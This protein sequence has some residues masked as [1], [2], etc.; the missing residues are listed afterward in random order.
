MSIKFRLISFKRYETFKKS[1]KRSKSI[2]NTI[3]NFENLSKKKDFKYIF[4][5]SREYELMK[6][7]RE[8]LE[9]IE[10][11]IDTLIKSLNTYTYDKRKFYILSSKDKKFF[12][13]A[14]R[15]VSRYKRDF[16]KVF[17]RNLELD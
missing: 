6:Q 12:N 5:S 11:N 17:R 2:L 14:F 1:I 4:P 16:S 10:K 7:D 3:I 13:K 9:E 8:S 15:T